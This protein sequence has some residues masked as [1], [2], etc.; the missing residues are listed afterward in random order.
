M[1]LRLTADQIEAVARV[2]LVAA[3]ASEE[4]ARRAAEVFRRATL[5]GL[6]HHDLTYL[7]Q[8]LAALSEG[9]IDGRAT[10]RLERRWPALEIYDA[11]G[12]LGES[13]CHFLV[14]RALAL[15]R[16]LG[17]GV[18]S[19]RRSNHFLAGVPYAEMFAEAGYLGLVWSNTDP[20]MSAPQGRTMVIGNNPLGFGAPGRPPLL[21]D[22][23]MAYAS[24]GTLA[25]LGDAEVPPWW[26]VDAQGEPARTAR[27]I[28]EGGVGRP[29]GEHKGWALA[30]MHECLTAGLAGAEW[31]AACAPLSG[32]LG[33]HAQ[34]VL[35]LA[36]P[37]GAED[38]ANRLRDLATLVRQRDPQARLSGERAVA[39]QERALAEGWELP[40][41]L[42]ERLREWAARLGVEGNALF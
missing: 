34:T 25:A 5:K 37:E 15:A 13:T 19:A 9:K 12:G 28:L 33:K 8:R 36:V 16:E 38:L 26:G 2:L 4:N 29:A 17:V 27:Q 18:C 14:E 11:G 1:S 35:A 42:E 7:P 10:P 20:S 3:G 23:C 41:R 31:A 24:L 32:G 30:L 39:F 22:L 6:G 21:V 40:P